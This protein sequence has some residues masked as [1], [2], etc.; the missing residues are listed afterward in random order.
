VGGVTYDSQFTEAE[1]SEDGGLHEYYQ[2]QA[3][4]CVFTSTQ[5]ERLEVA[6]HLGK[7]VNF[8]ANTPY[9]FFQEGR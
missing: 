8:I 3:N 9:M 4:A 7:A 5:D 6:D 1:L 2:H